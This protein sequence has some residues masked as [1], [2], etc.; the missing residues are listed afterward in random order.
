[1]KIIIV[2]KIYIFLLLISCLI[3]FHYLKQN[4]TINYYDETGYIALSQQIMEKGVFGFNES[5][6]TYLYP[7]LISFVRIFTG[8]A[9]H[10]TK[11][12]VSILQYV[13]Y[14]YTVSYIARQVLLRTNINA[15]YYTII[16]FG[17]LNPYLIQST[18]LFLTDITA[19][20]LIA[21]AIF[22][23]I[24]NRFESIKIYIGVF[25]L[26]FSAVMI[27][28]STLILVFSV[29]V[30]LFLRKFLLKD[31]SFL[32]GILAGVISSIIFLPQLYNNVVNYND[33]NILI[34]DKLYDFQS[35]LAATYLKYG[36]VVIPDE[37]PQLIY[38]TPFKIDPAYSIFDL[39]IHNIPAFLLAYFSH[40]F[41]V[42]D[43]GYIDT[44]IH[45]F[46]PASR[47]YAPILLYIFWAVS[48]YGMIV[49]LK[50]RAKTVEY[51]F[52]ALGFII[53][54]VVY[55][56]FI[57]TAVVES[58]FG[59]PLW[60]MALPFVGF[61]IVRIIELYKENKYSKTRITLFLIS[62]LFIMITSISLLSFKLELSTGRIN[63][64]GFF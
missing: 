3:F 35:R 42:L 50:N 43:W 34:H 33:W 8:D 46:Y 47:V 4:Y 62:I 9:M 26:S 5:L 45:D 41:G 1:M 13:L 31:L 52:M 30:L 51:K 15:M 54:F 38:A 14:I 29:F 22:I 60:F 44:Y 28:P 12:I 53:P 55:A 59:Y 7:L 21:L 63:W 61:G 25:M 23:T 32:K 20:C 37:V 11:V 58:R 18:T 57:G 24:F 36:T 64:F 6:R 19:C 40:I 16:C 10:Y 48:F 56:L 17:F 2:K 49:F 39:V 27:R